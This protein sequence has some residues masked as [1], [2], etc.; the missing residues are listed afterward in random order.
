MGNNKKKSRSSNR[1]GPDISKTSGKKKQNDGEGGG[2]GD[3]DDAA[4]DGVDILFYLR[5]KSTL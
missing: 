5:T 3:G 2:D 4:T 1:Q